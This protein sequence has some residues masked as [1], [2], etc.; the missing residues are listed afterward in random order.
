M[1]EQNIVSDLRHEKIYGVFSSQEIKK[2]GTGTTTRKTVS[3]VFWF[4]EEEDGDVITV[5]PINA[6][7]IP[8]G[9]KKIID[10]E[11]LFQKYS[12]EPEFY[13]ST[14]YPKIKELD[15]KLNNADTSRKRGLNF[16][17]ECEY[18]RVLMADV[19]NVRANF[20]IGLT[21]LERGD[22]AKATNIFERLINL[23][24]SYETKHKHL[25]NEFGINL[26]KSKLFEQSITYY[27]KAITINQ[28]D[29]NLYLNLARVYLEQENIPL[30]FQNVVKALEISPKNELA[31]KF[32]HWLKTK[33][34]ITAEQINILKT[35]EL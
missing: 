26:R 21:Y 6:N 28:S 23:E 30:C 19:S 27:Q 35:L 4:V 16:S 32:V 8:T 2:V 7:Y 15:D 33:K 22:T 1:S 3:K 12:P 31:L 18:D 29:E 10:R 24:G 11:E 34:M 13:A 25:F 9:A 17:A 14:V 5:Q 20:G